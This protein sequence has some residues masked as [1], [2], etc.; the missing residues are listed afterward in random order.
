MYADFFK[1]IMLSNTFFIVLI[2]LYIVFSKKKE[3]KEY[4][5]KF[6]KTYILKPRKRI[7]NF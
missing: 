5:E 7:N 6:S 4:T 1:I 3:P 2:S